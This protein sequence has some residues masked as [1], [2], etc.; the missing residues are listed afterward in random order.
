M[1]TQ[2]AW[3]G[4]KAEQMRIV[5]EI[6]ERYARTHPID[7]AGVAETLLVNLVNDV[8][9]S[10]EDA[11]AGIDEIAADMKSTILKARSH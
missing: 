4:D 11:L 9:L 8:A 10:T 1:K 5:R 7:M 6:F 3:A 2:S